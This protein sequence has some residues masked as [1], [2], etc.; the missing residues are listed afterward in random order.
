MTNITSHEG[1]EDPP[2]ISTVGYD[3]V[4]YG[5]N[6]KEYLKV[7]FEGGLLSDEAA[8]PDSI[9]FREDV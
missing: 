5:N 7:E 1:N 6:L 3:T 4:L 2:V 9:E 8:A